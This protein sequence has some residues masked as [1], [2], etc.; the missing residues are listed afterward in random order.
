VEIARGP[1][2]DGQTHDADEC[3][4][5]NAAQRRAGKK[6]N[7][8]RQWVSEANSVADK[9]RARRIHERALTMRRTASKTAST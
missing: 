9:K 5:K 2:A 7:R 4:V 6:K 1:C 8:E 3:T